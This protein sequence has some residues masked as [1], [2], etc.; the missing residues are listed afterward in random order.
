[1][2]QVYTSRYIISRTVYIVRRSRNMNIGDVL[3]EP[4]ANYDPIG[5]NDK[6]YQLMFGD[7]IFLKDLPWH[8]I[9]VYNE[10]RSS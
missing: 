10:R 5:A 3:L 8:N 9:T 2:A 6:A 4:F 1:M 7:A